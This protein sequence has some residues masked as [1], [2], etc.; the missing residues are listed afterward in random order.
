MIK[1]KKPAEEKTMGNF[2]KRNANLYQ[3]QLPGVRD[4]E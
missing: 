3:L 2:T 4:E 1:K